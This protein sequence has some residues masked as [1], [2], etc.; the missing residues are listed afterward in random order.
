MKK[1]DVFY[2]F[3]HNTR[4][5][6]STIV[7]LAVKGKLLVAGGFQGELICMH[8]D[9]PGVSCCCHLMTIGSMATKSCPHFNSG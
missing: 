4:L 3:H 8:L 7:V 5:V 1:G 2:E 9:R 6:K